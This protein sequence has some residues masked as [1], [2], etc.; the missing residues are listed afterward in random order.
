MRGRSVLVTLLIFAAMNLPA[1]GQVKKMR[2]GVVKDYP[3]HE[4]PLLAAQEQQL[5]RQQ[6]LEVEIIRFA[7][8]PTLHRAMAAGSLDM[9]MAMAASFVQAVAGGVKEVMVAD[10]QSREEYSVWVLTE[11][12]IKEARD[13]KGAR[14]GFLRLGSPSHAFA[15]V[16]TKA[17]GIEKE[18][19][20]V[21]TGG[22]AQQDAAMKAKAVDAKV[23]NFFASAPL[24]FIGVI[25]PVV[26]LSD[27]LP[28]EW[29]D[30]VLF[31]QRHLVARSPEQVGAAVKATLEGGAFVLKEASWTRGKLVSNFAYTPELATFIYP[32]L[33]YGK[34]GVINRNG[35]KNIVIFFVEYGI[36][37]KEKVPPLEEIY[38]SRFTG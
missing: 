31:A 2:F 27:F 28:K 12:P 22:L 11:S 25:R 34:D 33:K 20:F 38:D 1:L 37:A 24:S 30:Y 29:V 8:G 19:K 14:I 21:A 32:K 15:R 4:L 35:L 26:A 16:I 6:G 10:M 23:S 7:A 5:Y 13:L 9:G 36:I 18:V 3:P 17:L